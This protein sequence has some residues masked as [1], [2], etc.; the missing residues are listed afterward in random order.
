MPTGTRE[1]VVKKWF[2]FKHIEC[3][4]GTHPHNLFNNFI[5]KYKRLIILLIAILRTKYEDKSTTVPNSPWP[6]A[7][8]E[9]LDTR[10]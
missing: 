3:N 9:A 2:D 4:I 6:R 1:I 10:W 7:V 5:F 8:T